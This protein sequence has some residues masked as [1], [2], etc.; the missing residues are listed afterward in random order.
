MTMSRPALVREAAQ[1]AERLH[2]RDT[3][4]SR[5]LLL[6]IVSEFVASG[7]EDV[8]EEKAKLIK[9]L[10]LVGK[11][12]GGHLDRSTRFRNQYS[13]AVKVLVEVLNRDDLEYQ[14]LCRLFGWTGRMLLVRDKLRRDQES[15]GGTHT[16]RKRPPS[17][18]EVRATQIK[19]GDMATL[20]DLKKKLD[21]R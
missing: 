14:D 6:S 15:S 1:L 17:K 20:L 11:G 13:L 10:I 3:L 8:A 4:V 18:P 12:V 9:T 16:V 2:S 21:R 19:P 5:N 7:G